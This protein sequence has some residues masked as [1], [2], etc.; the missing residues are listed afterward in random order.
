MVLPLLLIFLF[1]IID[2]GRLL[3]EWNRAEK[4]TQMGSR[5]AAVTNVVAGGLRTTNFVGVTTGGP[6][7]TQGDLIP[8][9]ALGT[10]S[11]DKTSCTCSGSC[12]GGIP[13]TYDGDAFE[14]IVARIAAFKP[15]VTE[16]NVIVEYR[17]SGLGFAGDPT[18]MDISPIVSV[19]LTQLQFQPIT[20]LV[21]ASVTLPDF[22]SSL[23]M[24]DGIGTQ[25]N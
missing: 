6:A 22:A 8:A 10:I 23:T 14:A 4:A 17:G 25:S 3:W 24:E 21:L 19:R 15:D 16:D 13:G 9:A 18:G 1:G 20:T 12:P 11:C 2:G 5:F 7:L